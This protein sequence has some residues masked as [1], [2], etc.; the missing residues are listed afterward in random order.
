MSRVAPRFERYVAIGDSS[1]EGLKDPDGAGGYRG[2]SQRLAERIARTQGGLLYANLAVR[3]RRTRQVRDEQLA[4]ALAMR[5]D[6]ASV[7]AGTNDVVARNFDPGAVSRDSALMM[8]ELVGIGATV[9]T[10]TLPDL[11]PIMP[12]A[13][14]IAPRVLALNAG[15]RAAAESSGAILVDFAAHPIATDPR[16]WDADRIHANS[17]GHARIAEALAAA[18]GLP[19][20][21]ASW[22]EPLPALVPRPRA[23]RLVAEATW[24]AC[25]LLPWAMLSAL[26]ISLPSRREPKRPA[27]ELVLSKRAGGKA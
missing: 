26:G 21:D 11:T 17:A 23:H 18:L 15:L 9:L 5:P 19:D 24:M 12:L 3:G 20:S 2:W 16:L 13:R 6:L 27:L 1:T 10:F 4:P 14:A 22:R 25:H 8:R 7:F